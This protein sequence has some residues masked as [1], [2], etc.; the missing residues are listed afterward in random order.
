[1]TLWIKSWV[2]AVMKKVPTKQ[3]RFEEANKKNV[4]DC[5]LKSQ[6]NKKL[7]PLSAKNVLQLPLKYAKLKQK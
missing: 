7:F 6:P 3:L 1:M 5:K 2:E 4:P